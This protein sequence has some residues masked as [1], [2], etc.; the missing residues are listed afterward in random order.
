MGGK[1]D[2]PFELAQGEVL[3]RL[4]GMSCSARTPKHDSGGHPP[5]T[6]FE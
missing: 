3:I 5:Y 2:S 1:L 4:H 6:P